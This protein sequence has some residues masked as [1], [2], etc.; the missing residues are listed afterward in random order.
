MAAA[1]LLPTGLVVLR[2]E[3]FLF[4]EADGAEAVGRNAQGNEILLDGVGAAI[5]EAEVV[6]GGTTLV[7]MA[8]NSHFDGRVPFQEISGF[9]ERC[10]SIGTNVRLVVV[11][12]GVANF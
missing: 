9:R 4:A 7:A 2:A 3:G 11:K 6:L 5:A 10:T 8:L 1:V 12:V